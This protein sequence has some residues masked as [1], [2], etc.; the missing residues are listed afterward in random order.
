MRSDIACLCCQPFPLL[1][2]RS[3]RSPHEGR[4]V[5]V[6]PAEALPVP[7][8]APGP[9]PR[10]PSASARPLTSATL[11]LLRRLLLNTTISRA[12]GPLRGAD[13]RTNKDP[14]IN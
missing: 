12:R 10:G 14:A 6:S 2:P 11:L 5:H 8:P 1:W 3:S 7:G 13:G 9:T 4:A